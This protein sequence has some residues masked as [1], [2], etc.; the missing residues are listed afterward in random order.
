MDKNN[1][2]DNETRRIFSENQESFSTEDLVFHYQRE[3]RLASAP[4]SVQS[5]YN[6]A[7][8]FAPNG[9][10]KTLV[11]TKSSRMMLSV[12]LVLSLMLLFLRSFAANPS[13]TDIADISAA[14]S[15]FSFSDTVYV[16]IRCVPRNKK[17]LPP[18]ENQL[19]NKKNKDSQ[20]F[21]RTSDDISSGTDAAFIEMNVQ[22]YDTSGTLAAQHEISGFCMDDEMYF[23]TTFTDY[24]IVEIKVALQIENEQDSIVC[25]VEKK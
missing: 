24:D 3:K 19:P 21:E 20:K 9:L 6:D 7:E 15:A 14:V 4:K 1:F 18:S 23:R 25:K 5:L 13:R 16:S 11:R 17:N 10:L 8:K 12:I 2:A 22:A